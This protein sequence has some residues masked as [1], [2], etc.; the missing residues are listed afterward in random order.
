M[1]AGVISLSTLNQKQMDL[2][3][4]EASLVY[5]KSSMPTGSI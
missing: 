5:I 4:F 2:C 1:V 3:R